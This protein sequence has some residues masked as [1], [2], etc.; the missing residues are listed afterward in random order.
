MLLSNMYG[1]RTCKPHLVGTFQLKLSASFGVLRVACLQECLFLSSTHEC[2]L[3]G[4]P[5][6]S[7][8]ELLG[9]MMFGSMPMKLAGNSF[10]IHYIRQAHFSRFFQPVLAH[11]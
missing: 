10:K 1:V 3:F 9:E 6:S 11:A 7:D 8:A 5:Q 2:S 4:V